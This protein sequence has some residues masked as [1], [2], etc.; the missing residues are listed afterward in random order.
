MQVYVY[1]G[2]FC[3]ISSL[4]DRKSTVSKNQIK[5][6]TCSN[7]VAR[8]EKPNFGFRARKGLPILPH[9]LEKL[10]MLQAITVQR[11]QALLI[12]LLFTFELIFGLIS[13]ITVFLTFFPSY[14]YLIYDI[15]ETTLVPVFQF[16]Y[17]R[18]NLKY[19]WACLRSGGRAVVTVKRVTLR[20]IGGNNFLTGFN[21][22]SGKSSEK[23]P[24]KFNIIEPCM[25]DV[26]MSMSIFVHGIVNTG[27][28][29]FL[30][31]VL[32]V[33][34]NLRRKVV[35]KNLKSYAYVC[36]P[37]RNFFSCLTGSVVTGTPTALSISINAIRQ[38]KRTSSCNCFAADCFI[39]VH[40]NSPQISH[41][42]ES[43]GKG[44]LTPSSRY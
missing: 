42:A 21:W 19:T 34:L 30:N 31:S 43:T 36:T 38:P 5:T 2:S 33:I 15:V 29:C 12:D 40:A 26:D 37:F 1:H 7:T 20:L 24:L 3:N 6:V 39:S 27:N 10:V 35:C 23:P 25:K 13:F 14:Y 32:Q 9:N 22:S 4:A 11:L 44:Y 8:R 17:T 16:V 41:T 18:C 28:S